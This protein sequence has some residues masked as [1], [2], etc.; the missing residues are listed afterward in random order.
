MGAFVQKFTA[1][2]AAAQASGVGVSTASTAVTGGN[3]LTVFVGYHNDLARPESESVSDGT[4]TYVEQGVVTNDTTSNWFV[5]KFVAKN[6]T[7]GTRAVTFV[8]ADGNNFRS[9]T[10]VESSGG[11]TTAPVDNKQG[12]FQATPG[13][14][15]DAVTS[16][17][18]LASTG[19]GLLIA[20]SSDT[21]GNIAAPTAGTGM[22]DQGT[23]WTVTTAPSRVVTKVYASGT[24]QALF[25]AGN[26]VGHSTMIVLIKDQ[27]AAVATPLMGQ[28][29]T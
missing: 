27:V 20:L 9:I 15:A 17:A 21:G 1:E 13:T 10:V 25:T 23:A 28:I 11:D 18:A 24:Q 26:N 4:N 29:C 14:G 8:T 22:T 3:C 16:G 19:A 5:K 7:G 6:I 12:N 2:N